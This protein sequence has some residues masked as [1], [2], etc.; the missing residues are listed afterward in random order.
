ML[1][2]AEEGREASGSARAGVRPLPGRLRSSAFGIGKCAAHDCAGTRLQR[3]SHCDGPHLQFVLV[4]DD[5]DLSRQ[6][7]PND[8]EPLTY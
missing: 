3:Y 5:S 2:W 8:Y 7:T 4:F 1:V 6:M